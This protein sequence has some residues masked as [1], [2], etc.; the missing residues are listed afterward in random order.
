M[1]LFFVGIIF[2]G[3]IVGN[4]GQVWGNSVVLKRANFLVSGFGL[5]LSWGNS[6][7]CF[8]KGKLS[9]FWFWLGSIG[10]CI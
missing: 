8:A 1:N 10:L 4:K 6:Y 5:E 9:S 7:F 2:L 3:Q